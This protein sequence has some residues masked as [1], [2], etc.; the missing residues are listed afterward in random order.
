MNVQTYMEQRLLA[1]VD[2]ETRNSDRNE[3]ILGNGSSITEDRGGDNSRL[4]GIEK[5]LSMGSRYVHL[6]GESEINT[7]NIHQKALPRRPTN[8]YSRK[9]RSL[10]NATLHRTIARKRSVRVRTTYPRYQES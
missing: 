6:N 8:E 2:R 5:R 9:S 1:S 3:V 7:Y 4:I 10:V